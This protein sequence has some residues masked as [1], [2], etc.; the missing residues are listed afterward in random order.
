MGFIVTSLTWGVK[1]EVLGL[2]WELAIII[3]TD[4]ITHHSTSWHPPIQDSFIVSSLT[5]AEEGDG[6]GEGQAKAAGSS[7]GREE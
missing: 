4:I 6:G 3:T 7:R 1:E 2:L 5:S